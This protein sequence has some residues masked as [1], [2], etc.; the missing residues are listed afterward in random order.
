M[1]W[2]PSD[3]RLRDESRSRGEQ[4]IVTKDRSCPREHIATTVQPTLPSTLPELVR[5]ERAARSSSLPPVV[6]TPSYRCET[7]TGTIYSQ[8]P[9][10]PDAAALGSTS[11]PYVDTR[12]SRPTA[13][14][15][16]VSLG[17][18][19]DNV[20]RV[21]GGPDGREERRQDLDGDW[22]VWRYHR[23]L[24]TA[25][26]GHT[27]ATRPS[28]IL[29]FKDGRL[30]SLREERGIRRDASAVRSLSDEDALEITM[31]VDQVRRRV[32]WPHIERQE[33][34]RSSHRQYWSYEALRGPKIP[35]SV[36]R[37]LT[38]RPIELV[39]MDGILI[40]IK[41]PQGTR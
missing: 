29:T 5:R 21:L 26:T 36:G 13:T 7:A 23:Q 3:T 27:R 25:S 18:S 39:F 19:P 22:L 2:P 9:C 10:A 15:H 1:G 37:K 32:G 24:S 16:A 20:R 30:H 4:L 12:S 14:L 31:S 8:V 11:S 6:L 35:G 41:R 40:E 33:L 34:S 38:N 17:M 28:L